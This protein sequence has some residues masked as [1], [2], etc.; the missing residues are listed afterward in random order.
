MK[1]P[2]LNDPMELITKSSSLE[3]PVPIQKTEHDYASSH[4]SEGHS[5]DED[6]SGRISSLESTLER[7]VE[8]LHIWKNEAFS[9]RWLVEAIV[10]GRFSISKA[11]ELVSRGLA[12]CEIERL[13]SE[14]SPL[15]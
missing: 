13:R 6:L 12:T 14:D 7:T 9:H 3:S 11:K 10:S 4:E 15:D 2:K 8:L 5:S 1:D